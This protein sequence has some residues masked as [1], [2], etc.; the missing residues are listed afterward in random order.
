MRLV[1]THLVAVL[2][3]DL[4]LNV[5]FQADMNIIDFQQ[6]RATREGSLTWVVVTKMVMELKRIQLERQNITDSQVIKGTL[7]VSTTTDAVF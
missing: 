4:E 6:S 7:Q 3:K 2:R 5:I 1:R